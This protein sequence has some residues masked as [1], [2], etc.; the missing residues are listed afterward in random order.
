MKTMIRS[1]MKMLHE[2][3]EVE[4]NTSDQ[5]TSVCVLK[6]RKGRFWR[7]PDTLRHYLKP[8][9]EVYLKPDDVSVT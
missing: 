5:E 8:N 6:F 7:F 1:A 9:N 2:G 3:G 4:T